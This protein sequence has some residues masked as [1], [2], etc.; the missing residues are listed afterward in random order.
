MGVD[1]QRR[2]A[3][4]LKGPIWKSREAGRWTMWSELSADLAMV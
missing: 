1:C 4:C 2:T 3:T